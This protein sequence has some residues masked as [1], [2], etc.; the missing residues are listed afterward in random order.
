VYAGVRPAASI[1]S[2]ITPDFRMSLS[3]AKNIPFGMG[4]YRGFVGSWIQCQYL[5]I[6]R[7]AVVDY[8]SDLHLR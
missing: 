4:E 5:G 3:A 8:S 7:H 6:S 1:L 2:A